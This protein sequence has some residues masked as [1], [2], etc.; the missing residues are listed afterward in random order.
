[1]SN[2]NLKS[3]TGLKIAVLSWEIFPVFAGG[4]GVLVESLVEELKHQGH[5]VTTIIPHPMPEDP[6][7]GVVS[8]SKGVK[9]YLRRKPNIPG[10]NFDWDL[11]K[12]PPKKIKEIWP[13]LFSSLKGGKKKAASTKLYPSNTPLLT[14]CYAWAVLD[15]FKKEKAQFDLIIGMDWLCIASR[16]LLQENKIDLPFYYYINSTEIDRTPDKNKLNAVKS[17]IDLEAKAFGEGEH[18]FAVSETTKQILVEE[19]QVKANKITPI[20]NDITFEPNLLGFNQLQKGKNVLYIGR[21]AS[22]KGLNFLID[23]AEKVIKADPQIRFLLAG[24]G[25]LLPEIVS[26]VAQRNL[27]KNCLFTGWVNED[28][29][30]RLYRSSDLFVMPSPSEPFG[31]TAL[32]SI[33]SGVPVISSEKC[34]FLGVVPSTP[35]FRHYDTNQFKEMILYYL[36]NPDSAKS[37]L[38]QEQADLTNHSWTREVAKILKVYQKLTK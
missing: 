25:D 30:K 31:L 15:F 13:P 26:M 14:R 17:M 10:L 24:D 38:K 20:F 27:E 12:L 4:L 33:R 2:P 18:V 1:M 22:Q 9:K 21:I 36:S 5:Q 29:K 11:L 6:I 19:Y 28:E 35:T 23:T 7:E 16:Y 8:V 34:G 37:L 3:K 32:E